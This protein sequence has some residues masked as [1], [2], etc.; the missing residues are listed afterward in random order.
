MN[1]G[2]HINLTSKDKEL[3]DIT[4][5]ILGLGMNVKVPLKRSM[6]GSLAYHLQFSNV[7]LY[8]FSVNCGL[9]PAKSKTLD[10]INVPDKYY[11]HFLR[12]YFDGDGCVYGFWDK[13]WKNSLMYYTEYTSASSKFLEWLRHQNQRLVHTSEGRI[14]NSTRALS[15]S[16]AKTD[17]RLLFGYMYPQTLHPKLS[18][19]YNK[20]VDLLRSDPY[21][22]KKLS[23]S[24]GIGR[25]AS[26][27]D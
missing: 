27:R 25:Q 1:N 2:R 14:K 19:K 4:Q 10:A 22:I 6:H 11:A 24:A 17:S 20:F 3:I 16:Y 12:G 18:R 5:N 8:D 7:S 23:A 9:T 13:R 26:L 15:L 21:A